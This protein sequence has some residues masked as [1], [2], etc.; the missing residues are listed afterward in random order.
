[1][2]ALIV[3][4]SFL[5]A[6]AGRAIDVDPDSPFLYPAAPARI[7]AAP[8]G[9]VVETPPPTESPATDSALTA[10]PAVYDPAGDGTER[11]ADLGLL[12]DGNPDTAW[13]TER[14]DQPLQTLSVWKT[15][16]R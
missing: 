13:R 4:A 3:A 16:K 7:E 6:V 11:D 15:T 2:S 14:W 12:A 5:I 10:A 1:M 8:D 9:D